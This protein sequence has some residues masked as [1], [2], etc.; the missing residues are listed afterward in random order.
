MTPKTF[1]QSLSS[2]TAFE[3]YLKNYFLT[4]KSL[5]GSYETHEYFEDYSVRLNRHSTLTLK[6]T[7]C[8]DIAAAAIPLKQTENI[9]FHD[10]RRL[11][12]NKKFADINE[13]LAEVFERSLKG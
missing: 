13:T 9:S 1:K 10:F 7:T 4:N 12:L 6:T 5:N 3:N 11:I 2:D 8:L